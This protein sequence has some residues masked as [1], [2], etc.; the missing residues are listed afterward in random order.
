[1]KWATLRFFIA[2]WNIDQTCSPYLK[3]I[4]LVLNSQIKCSLMTPMEYKNLFFYLAGL[5]LALSYGM[6]LTTYLSF[7]LSISHSVQSLFWYI[8]IVGRIDFNFSHSYVT[9]ND[10]SFFKDWSTVE[11]DVEIN[12]KRPFSN[13]VLIEK[14]IS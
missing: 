8:V 10:R 1:M 11:V 14:N 9:I 7:N 2:S 6:C 12:C 3:N 5:S 4:F 13:R